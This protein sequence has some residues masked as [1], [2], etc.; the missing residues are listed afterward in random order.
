MVP[1]ISLSRV[2]ITKSASVLQGFNSR[3]HRSARRRGDPTAAQHNPDYGANDPEKRA[4]LGRLKSQFAL[5]A[6]GVKHVNV[7]LGWHGCDEAVTDSVI[8]YGAINLSSPKDRG[9]F[10]SGIYLTP[11]AGYAAGYSTGLLKTQWRPPNANGEHVLLLCAAHAGLAYPITRSKDY[12][13]KVPK[14]HPHGPELCDYYGQPFDAFHDTHYVQVSQATDFQ[15]TPR[16]GRY[17]FEEYVLSQEMQCLPF[18]K[19]FVKVD[20]DALDTYLFG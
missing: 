19:V 12:T 6:D 7:L 14:Q 13:G 11:Q 18:A 10:G 3:V 16:P 20:R 8:A 17:D 5:T 15:A 2:E 9:Y 4:M 1:G